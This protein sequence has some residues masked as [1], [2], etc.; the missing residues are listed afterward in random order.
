MAGTSTAGGILGLGFLLALSASTALDAADNTAGCTQQA[1]EI[2]PA[3]V[4]A[5]CTA[6][7]QNPD[8]SI[9]AQSQALFIRG[10][11]YHRTKQIQLAQTD[12][13][14]ALKLAPDNDAI[15]PERANV[16]IRLGHFEE[17]LALLK[18]ALAIN[19]KNAHALRM[20]GAY[21][22][23]AGQLDQAIQYLSMALDADPA[24]AHALLFR[25]YIYQTQKRLDLALR[26]ANAL[27]AMPA[28]E[29]NRKGY[30]GLDGVKHDFHIMALGN[31]ADIYSAIGKYDLA[32][33]DLDAAVD[34]KRSAASL[35]ARGEFLM[36]RPGQQQRALDDL[37]AATTLDP[38][39]LHPLYLKGAVLVDLKR[40]DEALAA[41]DRALAISP[42]YDYALRL[43]AIAYRALGKTDLA[44]QDLERAVVTSPRVAAMTIR[45]LQIAGYWPYGETPHALTPRLQDA[46]RACMLDKDCH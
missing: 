35:E 25:S 29:I 37:E 4:I 44:V 22:R 41:L 32:E 27:V 46:I 10:Q 11:G 23:D 13:D 16:A 34:Y 8:L 39:S 45:S 31:R 28:A 33:Q 21:L 19:P 12:Y 40:Y 14:A 24:E 20:I 1:V 43:R 42:N 17:W 3:A 15:Y 18:R 6:L 26:D 9:A 2:D 36:D 5:P 38:D 7:L 30:L